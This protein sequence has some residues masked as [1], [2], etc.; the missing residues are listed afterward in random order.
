MVKT[1][2][3]TAAPEGGYLVSDAQGQMISGI[4]HMQHLLAYVSATF[5]GHE[6]AIADMPKLLRDQFP[7][8]AEDRKGPLAS[9]GG[10]LTGR[11]R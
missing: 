6:S 10:R 8:A 7:P 4:T 1:I 9:L 2:M 5:D 3:I 11:G